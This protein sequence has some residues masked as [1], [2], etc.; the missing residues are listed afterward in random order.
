[1]THG[2]K[3]PVPAGVLWTEEGVSFSVAVPKGKKC[4][5]CL[6]RGKKAEPYREIEMEED[7]LYG[8]IR[9]SGVQTG[10]RNGDEYL[11]F[12][13][14]EPYVDPYAHGISR[15]TQ[16]VQGEQETVDTRALLC[17]PDFN[18]EGDRPLD[19]PDEEIIA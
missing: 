19:L 6:Y 18:W 17:A 11:Y 2:E 4:R 13:D 9:Y 8:D 12:I 14:G 3:K 16:A 7:I 10:I 15:H 5:L 1:M